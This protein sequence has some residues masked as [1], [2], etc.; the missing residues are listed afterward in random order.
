MYKTYLSYNKASGEFHWLHT[1]SSTAIKGY[2]AGSI[3]KGYRYIQLH[4]KKVAAHQ[5]AYWW[6]TEEWVIDLDHI[7]RVK[8]NNSFS[9]L[10]VATRREQ[11]LN[12]SLQINNRSGY[13][14]I[15]WFK[16]TSRWKVEF[17]YNGRQIHVGYF[18]DIKEAIIHRDIAKGRYI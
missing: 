4:G 3:T 17:K 18:K 7:D 9:N 14:N 12:R 16:R 13:K 10:R 2:L 6:I 11:G 5:L 15:T 1:V 8:D